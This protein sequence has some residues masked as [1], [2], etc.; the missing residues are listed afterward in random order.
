MCHV[1][2]HG[3]TIRA[4]LSKLLSMRKLVKRISKEEA[5]QRVAD[6][7]CGASERLKAFAAGVI[8]GKTQYQA[9]IDAGYS[10]STAAVACRVLLPRAKI[11]FRQILEHYA[12]LGKQAKKIA[13]GMDAT[14][15][16]YFT[17]EGKVVDSREDADYLVRHKYLELAARL[18][19]TLA[20]DE[21]AAPA[22]QVSVQFVRMGGSTGS[23]GGTSVAPAPARAQA[24]RVTDTTATA[25]PSTS[26][27]S[28]KPA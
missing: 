4:C 27:R 22:V 7:A 28:T 5:I 2:H 15:K 9:A 1:A 12:P 24:A 19:G 23:T 18:Q 20:D 6:S 26:D 13:E 10:A 25:L 17:Y 14:K 3:L 21:R 16:S 8:E 11:T